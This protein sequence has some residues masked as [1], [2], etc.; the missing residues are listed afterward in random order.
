MALMENR[1]SS[2]ADSR[3]GRRLSR[4]FPA[5]PPH[6]NQRKELRRRQVPDRREETHQ[7]AADTPSYRQYNQ[8]ILEEQM[9][10]ARSLR[11]TQGH[12]NVSPAETM[13]PLRRPADPQLPALTVKAVSPLWQTIE[14]SLQLSDRF[15]RGLTLETQ[16]TSVLH[17]RFD[18]RDLG[19]FHPFYDDPKEEG[20]VYKD[21]DIFYTD[22]TRFSRHLKTYNQCYGTGR[23]TSHGLHSLTSDIHLQSHIQLRVA[24]MT[25]RSLQ[26]VY[27]AALPSVLD[28]S[29]FPHSLNPRY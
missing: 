15:H 11:Q 18:R 12:I 6:Q 29:F 23:N 14:D 3:G 16:G 13:I 24:L 21:K 28:C 20:V 2:R 5:T 7:K 19:Y 25:H 8:Y 22:V 1:Q 27:I 17:S 10:A 26:L 4:D 9:E